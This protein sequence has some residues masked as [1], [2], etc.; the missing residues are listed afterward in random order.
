MGDIGVN[1]QCVVHELEEMR[2]HDQVIFQYDDPPVPVDH[3]G[4]TVYDVPCQPPVLFP[5]RDVHLPEAFGFPYDVPHFFHGCAV[6]LRTRG[7]GVDE[8]VAVRRQRV[9]RQCL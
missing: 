8:Q 9:A 1:V 4:D 7:I 2:S 6:G 5:F 3:C